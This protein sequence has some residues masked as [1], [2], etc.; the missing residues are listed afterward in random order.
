[1][2]FTI[3]FSPGTPIEKIHLQDNF[4]MW[5]TRGSSNRHSTD[6]STPS[7]SLG[8]AFDARGAHLQ[9]RGRVDLLGP[10]PTL[11]VAHGKAHLCHCGG[12]L[13]ARAPGDAGGMIFE[14]HNVVIL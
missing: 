11:Q 4:K 14:K 5:G 2:I 12:H 1:M 10:H 9:H 8:N 13:P 3:L 6:P 7:D